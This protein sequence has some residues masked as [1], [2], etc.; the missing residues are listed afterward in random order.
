MNKQTLKTTIMVKKEV[1]EPIEVQ[2]CPICGSVPY[3]FCSVLS[4]GNPIDNPPKYKDRAKWKEPKVIICCPNCHLE[5]RLQDWNK[6]SYE[7]NDDK[8]NDI[9]SDDEDRLINAFINTFLSRHGIQGETPIEMSQY[10]RKH[11]YIGEM[12]YENGERS[13]YVL[14]KDGKE[15]ARCKFINEENEQC[16]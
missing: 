9:P 5:A 10:M 7:E 1:E 14:Y 15:I 4:I 2:I 16:K 3:A 13:G 12:R 8:E 11:G 6:L